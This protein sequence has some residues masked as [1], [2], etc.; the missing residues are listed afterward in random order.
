MARL[1]VFCRWQNGSHRCTLGTL[2]W[3]RSKSVWKWILKIRWN[4]NSIWIRN[5]LLNNS[6]WTHLQLEHEGVW[7]PHQHLLL[8]VFHHQTS[9]FRYL[10]FSF[11]SFSYHLDYFFKIKD[12]FKH[13]DQCFLLNNKI[14]LQMM[15]LQILHHIP[16]IYWLFINFA[17]SV[18]PAMYF[19]NDLL[20]RDNRFLL[21]DSN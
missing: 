12:C 11:F 5:F 18:L 9:F 10:Y 21:Q 1:K 17:Q 7:F 19:Q 3:K 14:H 15:N 6:I 16:I 13:F 20:L 4:S 2:E 8:I